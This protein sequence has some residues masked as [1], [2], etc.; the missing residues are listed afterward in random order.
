[1]SSHTVVD[2][3]LCDGSELFTHPITQDSFAVVRISF[4]TFLILNTIYNIVGFTNRAPDGVV[5]MVRNQARNPT[6]TVKAYTVSTIL[7][8]EPT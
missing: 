2:F 3:L 7:T 5:T 4:A 6:Q 1:M 8:L